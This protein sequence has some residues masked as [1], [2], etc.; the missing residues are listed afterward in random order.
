MDNID[1]AFKAW[2]K[3]LDGARAM[4]EQAWKIRSVFLTLASA[5]LAYAYTN[6]DPLLYLLI[7]I[8]SVLFILIESLYR[9][10]E[11]Q[12]YAS[13]Q[14]VEVTLNDYLVGERRP[15]LPPYG[16]STQ[17]ET[18]SIRAFLKLFRLKRF[19]FWLP[20][21]VMFV[22]PLMLNYFCIVRAVD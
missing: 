21:L 17:L 9:R 15:R 10:L 7:P 12:Y 4:G 1:L 11:Q 2:E 3:Y 16:I 19:S 22:G 5:L 8:L 20:Y 6:L 14:Q 13:A 18:P